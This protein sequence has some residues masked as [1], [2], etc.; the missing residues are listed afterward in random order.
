MK[1]RI[2]FVFILGILALGTLASC[3]KDKEP[4]V[5]M[6]GLFTGSFVGKYMGVDTLTS[7]GYQV[8]VTALNDNKVKIEGNNFEMFEVL[9]TT[10]GLNIESVSK[11]DPYL[12]DFIYI[13]DDNKL[14]FKFNKGAN[15]A[16][17]IGIK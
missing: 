13:G 9:V 14:K 3:N 4:A 15:K 12:L 2:H 10:N 16:E 6:S 8:Q 7:D 5:V 1:K 17:F 11:S